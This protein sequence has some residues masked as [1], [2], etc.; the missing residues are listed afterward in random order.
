MQIHDALAARHVHE[1]DP[2]YFPA[3]EG[4]VRHA[5]PD[6]WAEHAATGA[7]MN[8]GAAR[9]GAV[10]ANAPLEAALAS[11]AAWRHAALASRNSTADGTLRRSQS[12]PRS[13]SGTSLAAQRS[14]QRSVDGVTIPRPLSERS[15]FASA[16]RRAGAAGYAELAQRRSKPPRPALAPGAQ[17]R[18]SWSSSTQPVA[19]ALQLSAQSSAPGSDSDGALRA[20][21][22]LCQSAP[23]ATVLEK[24][25]HSPERSDDAAAQL[26]GRHSSARAGRLQRRSLPPPVL[27]PAQ[28]RSPP[29]T[30]QPRTPESLRKA[31][32]TSAS[33]DSSATLRAAG[34][35]SLQ[36][37]SGGFG[38]ADLRA[39]AQQ[40]LGEQAARV[41]QASSRR[42]QLDSRLQPHAG[43]RADPTGWGAGPQW[44]S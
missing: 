6:R 44:Q 31:W 9:H 43:Y 35:S 12:L 30:R 3:I 34:T 25:T 26:F 16:R 19:L 40:Y 23:L 5:Y 28:A 10:N 2:A 29:R 32:N 21:S 22:Q 15:R 18:H 7:R 20:G 33:F 27:P 11:R 13:D 4:G 39:A 8:A 14:A 41:Q 42:L 38:P 37:R 17:L 24:S 36:L 1:G